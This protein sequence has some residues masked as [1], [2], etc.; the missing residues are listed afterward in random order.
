MRIVVVA[1]VVEMVI[2]CYGMLSDGVDT[3]ERVANGDEWQRSRD[4]EEK[5]GLGG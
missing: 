5:K 1:A 3:E 4:G 2:G